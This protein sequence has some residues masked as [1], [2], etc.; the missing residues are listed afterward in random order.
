MAKGIEQDLIGINIIGETT[1]I[2]GNIVT[3]GDMRIDG[4]LKGDFT[5]S[6]K[7]VVSQTGCIKGNINCNDCDI[8]GKVQG[9]ITTSGLLILRSTATVLGDIT[10]FKLAIE[11]D[12]QF[13][14]VCKMTSISQ[15]HSTK[16]KE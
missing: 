9:N 2:E 12:G 10:I 15:S 14:G 5:S 6:Q 3:S 16:E 4:K 7:L 8:S 13:S 1:E 11:P